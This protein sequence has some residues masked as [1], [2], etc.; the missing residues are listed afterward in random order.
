MKADYAQTNSGL[1]M[2]DIQTPANLTSLAGTTFLFV[3]DW[4]DVRAGR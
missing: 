3:V 2:N 1:M 4:V